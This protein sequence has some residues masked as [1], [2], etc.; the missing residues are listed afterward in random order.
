ME[1][2][3]KQSAKAALFEQQF[4]AAFDKYMDQKRSNVN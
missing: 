4:A 3:V 2:Q 1:E